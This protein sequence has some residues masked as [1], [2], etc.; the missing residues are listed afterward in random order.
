[1]VS[2]NIA[3]HADETRA[4]MSELGTEVRKSIDA[5]GDKAA[6]ALSGLGTKVALGAVG[7]GALHALILD[8]TLKELAGSVTPQIRQGLESL[9]LIAAAPQT[10]QP[11]SLQDVLVSEG[12]DEVNRRARPY[13][14]QVGLAANSG[15]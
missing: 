15:G 14:I 11:L 6:S 1:M 2:D 5:A 4:G 7:A 10:T 8:G 12:L 9:K 13:G 3:R